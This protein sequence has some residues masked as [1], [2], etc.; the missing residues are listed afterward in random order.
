VIRDMQGKGKTHELVILAPEVLPGQAG[1]D[2]TTQ[3]TLIRVEPALSIDET[4]G[5]P[6]QIGVEMLSRFLLPFELVSLLLLMAMVGAIILTRE[7]VA[8]RVRTRLVVS[9]VVRRI[10]R[11]VGTT[12]ASGVESSSD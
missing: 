6:Q 2:P 4:Y 12:P 8:K 1:A 10:N 11:S 3:P 7:D 5:S 9:P